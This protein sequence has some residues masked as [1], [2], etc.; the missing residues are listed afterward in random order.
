MIT[1][2][3]A[4]VIDFGDG[5]LLDNGHFQAPSSAWRVME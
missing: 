3:A 5:L 1:C 2:F 4:T